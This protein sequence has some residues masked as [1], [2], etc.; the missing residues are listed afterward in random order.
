LDANHF[1]EN[2]K[3]VL[4]QTM[5]LAEAIIARGPMP[6]SPTCGLSLL[7]SSAQSGHPAVQKYQQKHTFVPAANL[8]VLAELAA[9]RN[10]GSRGVSMSP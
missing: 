8:R 4:S 2:V 6:I 9:G 10:R 7:T 3:A 5:M 1:D